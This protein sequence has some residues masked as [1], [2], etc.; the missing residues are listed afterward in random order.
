MKIRA[1]VYIAVSLDGYI[2]RKNGAIDFLDTFHARLPAVNAVDNM[3]PEDL[4]FGYQSFMSDIDHIVMGRETFAQV[5]SFPS[6]PYDKPVSVLSASSVVQV[7]AAL[8]DS[9]TQRSG[10]PSDILRAI[11]ETGAKHV[12]VDGGVTIQRFLQAKCVHDMTIS[13][14]PVLLGVGRRLFGDTVAEEDEWLTLEYC[15][16]FR[17][18]LTQ[19]KYSLRANDAEA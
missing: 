3:S 12:Y 4:D 15:K 7:P 14:I 11:A 18:G 9:V 8:R 16:V 10:P 17:G 5:S 19:H 6:W 13:T 1:S 2:S